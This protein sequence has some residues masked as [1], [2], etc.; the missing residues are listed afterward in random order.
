VRKYFDNLGIHCHNDSG[1]AV[2]NTLAAVDSGV[3]HVQGCINGYGERTGNADLSAVIPNLVLKKS[4][5][6][7]DKERLKLITQVSHHIAELINVTPS[8]Q[9]PYVGTAAFA[10]KAGLHTSA[11]SRRSDAYEH[12]TPDLVGNGTRFLVSEMS[13]RATLEL[14]AKEFG[15]DLDSGLISRLSEELKRREY[16]GYHYEAADASFELLVLGISGWKQQYFEVESFRVIS[17]ARYEE[18]PVGDTV[19]IPSLTTEATVKVHVG[20][21]RIVSTCEGNG[22]VNALDKALRSAIEPKYPRLKSIHLTDYRVRVLDTKKGTGAVTRV[23]IDTSDED[24]TWTTIGVSDN[25]IEASWEALI[26]A[27]I[28]ALL[29]SS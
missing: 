28:Y 9:Q 24:R 2:A 14:R 15:I 7:I 12:I 20:S 6:V 25:I 29:K 16:E 10:H 26:D 23:L 11:I 4:I 13:G 8:P 22:P 3:I 17:D 5:E 21:E 19:Q 1:C 27:I 18:T